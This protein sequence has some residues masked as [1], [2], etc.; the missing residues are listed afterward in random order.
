MAH[1]I[2]HLAATTEA[3]NTQRP[4]W[5]I[6]RGDL[7]TFS[8]T[9]C[10]M[11]SADEVRAIVGDFDALTAVMMSNGTIVLMPSDYIE[12]VEDMG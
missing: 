11:M 2:K 4:C 10:R 6:K 12:L 1:R 9:A 7:R 8:L 5:F 3:A